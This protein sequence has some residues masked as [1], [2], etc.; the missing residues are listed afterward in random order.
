MLIL[1]K[2]KIEIKNENHSVGT[3]KNANRKMVERWKFTTPNTQIHD[4]RSLSWLV[5]SISIKTN[6][7]EKERGGVS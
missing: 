1:Q 2:I 7:R 3:A 5:T 6:V 4:D